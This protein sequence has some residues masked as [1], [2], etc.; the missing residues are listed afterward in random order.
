MP[1]AARLFEKFSM[2]GQGRLPKRPMHPL[3]EAMERAGCRFDN[4]HLPLTCEGKMASGNFKIGG[5]VSSQFASGLLLALPLM[6]AGS[7]VEIVGHLESAGYVNMTVEAIALFGVA[8]EKNEDG[9]YRITGNRRYD[10]P[11]LAVPEGDWSNAAF[12]LCSGAMGGGAVTVRG[13]STGSEQRDKEVVDALGRFGAKVEVD[14]AAGTVSASSSGR[15]RATEI[16]ATHVTDL[17]PAL[18]VV[19][20]VAEGETRIVNAQRLRFKESDRIKST[21]A[22]L[23]A[24]GADARATSDGIVIRGKQRLRGGVVNGAG[25]HRIVMAAATAA[26]ACERQ[27]LIEDFLSVNKSYPTFFGDFK[28]LKGISDVV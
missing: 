18:A 25:D 12:F 7:S 5:D 11:G 17:I 22:M 8:I 23:S 1:V 10:S 2:T 16:D 3:C 21:C 9:A 14:E 28:T 19:A 27:V 26:C 24:L 13:L 4:D 6:D 15:L 20:S